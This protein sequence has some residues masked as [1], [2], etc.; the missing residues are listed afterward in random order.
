MATQGRRENPP[1]DRLL[2]ADGAR[3]E[4]FQAVRLL[5]RLLPERRPVGREAGASLEVVRFRTDPSLTF[6]ASDISSISF[7]DPDSVVEMWVNFMGLIGPNGVLPRHYTEM[8]VERGRRRDH[9]IHAFLDIFNHRLISLFY[10]AWERYRFPVAFERRAVSRRDE[11][12]LASAVD[13]GSLDGFS[14]HLLDFIG[15]GTEG[16]L[17]PLAV[18][19]RALL[20]H[21]GILGRKV[22]SAV[23]LEGL[24]HG[25]F[26]VGVDVLQFTGQWLA[27]PPDSITRLGRANSALG[28]S[29]VLGARF[30]DP[31]TKFT[32]R[33]GPMGVIDFHR[34]L[35][36]GDAI[37]P[38][39]Q[40]T[41]YFAGEELDFDVQPVLAA[42]EVPECRLGGEPTHGS[43]L[44]WSTWLKVR[45]FDRDADD[46]VFDGRRSL[47]VESAVA[48]P[49]PHAAA[50]E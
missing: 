8:V 18:D 31:Q 39:T 23:A 13:V 49:P 29:A 27:I 9:A 5:E 21:A 12:T 35:P 47:Q 7:D 2:L 16:L 24:L 46:A 4:F 37:R 44:G 25:Y 22:R 1:L 30:W 34:F 6:P 3:F 11:D 38:L 15:L 36:P 43:Y 33:L 45:P 50:S 32:V 14:R 41:A 26:R 17:R 19:L 48:D 42:A 10:R 40:L 28:D 20:F